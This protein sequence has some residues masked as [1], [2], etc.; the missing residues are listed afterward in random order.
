M[1][2]INIQAKDSLLQ[3]DI[4]VDGSYL[5]EILQRFLHGEF[6]ILIDDGKIRYRIFTDENDKAYSLTQLIDDYHNKC[7]Y[8]PKFRFI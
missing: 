4:E 5:Q 2:A 3:M 6:S 1:K 7:G 8:N